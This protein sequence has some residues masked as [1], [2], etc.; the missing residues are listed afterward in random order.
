[1][2]RTFAFALGG[3]VVLTLIV[4]G[5]LTADQVARGD[6]ILHFTADYIVA[7][8]TVTA[9]TALDIPS[10]DENRTVSVLISNAGPGQAKAEVTITGSAPSGCSA[11]PGP[12]SGTGVDTS[13]GVELLAGTNTTV[14]RDF[15]INCT[16][17]GEKTF[18][19]SASVSVL[20][21]QGGGNT[22]E[23]PDTSTLSNGPKTVQQTV[24]VT[25]I[26]DLAVTAPTVTLPG[27]APPPGADFSVTVATTASNS[28]FS[29]ANADLTLGLT[30]VG[31]ADCTITPAPQVPGNPI[32]LG[33]NT[34]VSR[35]FTV[36]CSLV[37]DHTF[38][39][40]AEIALVLTANVSENNTANN[41]PLTTD[42]IVNVAAIADLTII[43]S[44]ATAAPDTST[45]PGVQQPINCALPCQIT[46]NTSVNNLGPFDPANADVT[47]TLTPPA[48]CDAG[49]G[50][51][52]AASVSHNGVSL[53]GPT[54]FSDPFNVSCTGTG[55]NTF[56]ATA[57]IAL[58]PGQPTID[59]PPNGD[60][61]GP[62]NVVIEIIADGD[63]DGVPDSADQ[64]LTLDEDGDS[65]QDGD[66]CPDTNASSSVLN[67]SAVGDPPTSGGVDITV[68]NGNYGPA[69]NVVNDTTVVDLS[70]SVTFSV[71][72]A[73]ACTV[74]PIAQ[75]AD[76]DTSAVT[77]IGNDAS[78]SEEDV[79][80]SAPRTTSLSYGVSSCNTSLTS[81][82]TVT[83]CTDP[84][85]DT[86]NASP[87]PSGEGDVCTSTAPGSVPGCCYRVD[88]EDAANNTSSSTIFLI[89]TNDQDNDGVPDASDLCPD[90]P[91]PTP[92]LDSTGFGCAQ[93]QV[94]SDLD[95]FCD[96]ATTAGYGT[97]WC[98]TSPVDNCPST[99]N[100][101]QENT[102]LV[103]ASAGATIGGVPLGDG[104]GDACDDD[105]DDDGSSDILEGFLGTD[106]LDNCGVN[107]WPPDTSDNNF[108]SAGDFGLILD[109]WQLTDGVDAGY[110]RRAD[111]TGNGTVSAGDF[112]LILDFWQLS[113]T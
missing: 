91:Q 17:L 84:T 29:P 48:G 70:V 8:P 39:G 54:N 38:R 33:A 81:S 64:C 32:S 28:G 2:L 49:A 58:S 4:F 72:P 23:D 99:S 105:D 45:A 107:A 100:P 61:A 51:G 93:S 46:I 92:P 9:D 30:Q 102:D 6:I 78:H 94:D 19:Y 55:S 75:P 57:T 74:T 60:N 27:S 1:M 50:A 69:A 62:T 113:C 101:G 90:T 34:G 82:L 15:T 42:E 43:I 112:G 35:G 26:V 65:I 108:V 18:I 88:E 106:S 89:V 95:G 7:T 41:G 63:G 80:A 20:A 37:G 79:L 24:T 87:P 5:A 22:G 40:S 36:N 76:G 3:G 96:D 25:G 14:F 67:L 13:G 109:S 71:T 97:N 52:V 77:V 31:P 104:L 21:D 111:L 73:G 66:G 68:N 53:G 103:L 85:A 56:S 11:T 86:E 10:P 47:V 110:I 44:S 83:A 59:N 98:P 12:Y 16:A